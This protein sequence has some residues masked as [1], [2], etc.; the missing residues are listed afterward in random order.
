M[1]SLHNEDI[2]HVSNLYAF[3]IDFIGSSFVENVVGG[4]QT[5]PGAL[6]MFFFSE[7]FCI[8]MKIS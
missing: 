7:N 1:D 2:P 8:L 6:R 5:M 4:N 3:P